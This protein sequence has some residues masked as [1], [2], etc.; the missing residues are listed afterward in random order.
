MKANL[1]PLRIQISEL[2]EINYHEKEQNMREKT[3]LQT[4]VMDLESDLERLQLTNKELSNK[5]IEAHEQTRLY[6]ETNKLI[7]ILEEENK[8]LGGKIIVL[9]SKS[10]ALNNRANG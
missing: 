7:N 8:M 6:E 10:I 1:E 5:L 3:N 2:H 9:E 4:K